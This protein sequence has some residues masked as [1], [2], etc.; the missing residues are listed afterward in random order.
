MTEASQDSP[1]MAF[2]SAILSAI[3]AP[4][5]ADPGLAR[6]AAREAIAAHHPGSPADTIAIGQNIAFALT[7]LDTLRLS[8][9]AEVPLSMKLKLRANANAANRAACPRR[10]EMP[11]PRGQAGDKAGDTTEHLPKSG[12]PAAR[13]LS[14]QDWSSQMQEVATKLQTKAAPDKTDALWIDALTSVATEI[15]AEKNRPS[16]GRAALLRSTWMASNPAIPPDLFRVK[17]K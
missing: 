13:T 8:M 17:A 9:P 11:A 6:R 5:L 16:A 1:L 10:S 7:A 2:I 3:M 4:A 15:A 12:P 14:S